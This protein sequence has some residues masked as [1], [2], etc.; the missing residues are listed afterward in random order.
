M[1]TQLSA[2]QDHCEDEGGVVAEMVT[3]SQQE[4]LLIFLLVRLEPGV[5]CL[6][7]WGYTTKL[8]SQPGWLLT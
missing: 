2:S 7:G 1:G 3:D 5:L 8:H 6:L 4:L